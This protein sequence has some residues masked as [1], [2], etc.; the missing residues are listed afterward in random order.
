MC[1]NTVAPVTL[2]PVEHLFQRQGERRRRRGRRGEEEEEE[3]GREGGRNSVMLCLYVLPC[4][5]MDTEK[6]S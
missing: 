5:T 6:Q 2:D 4:S 1:V 3:G